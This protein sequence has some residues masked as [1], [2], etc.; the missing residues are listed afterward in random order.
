M[1]K[2]ISL[3]QIK[4][5]TFLIKTKRTDINVRAIVWVLPAVTLA[6]G[7]FDLRTKPFAMIKIY[8]QIIQ[9]PKGI[10][11]FAHQPGRHIRFIVFWL[12]FA[13]IVIVIIIKFSNG[14]FAVFLTC[15]KYMCHQF[16]VTKPIR[17]ICSRKMVRFLSDQ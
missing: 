4:T 14:Y 8:M 1:P 6:Q 11:G 10:A 3:E 17:M 2:R 7:I 9:M 15:S 16:Q 5:K 13:L 12:R